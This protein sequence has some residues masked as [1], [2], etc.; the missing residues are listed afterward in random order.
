MNSRYSPPI[1]GNAKIQ[2]TWIGATTVILEKFENGDE[3]ARLREHLQFMTGRPVAALMATE[4]GG[5]NGVLPIT[6]AGTGAS[7]S[8]RCDS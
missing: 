4:I 2:A 6:W 1:F 8:W 3:G 5:G 7:R